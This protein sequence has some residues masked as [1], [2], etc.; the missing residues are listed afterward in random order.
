[1]NILI[2]CS[3][4]S[5]GGGGQVADSICSY[6]N[7]FPQHRFVIVYSRALKVMG[8]KVKEY[9]NVESIEYNYPLKDY[10]SLITGRNTYLD[11]LVDN[12]HID[13]VLTV[14]GPMKWKPYCPHVCGFA[15][16]H[17][18]LPESPYFRSLPLKQRLKTNLSMA[19]DTFIFRHGS[20][21]LY[22]EN[23]YITERV[24]R[25]INGSQVRTISNNYNQVFDH[26]DK[27]V[28]RRLEDF[29]GISLLT[30]ASP[31]PHK[32]IPI[33]IQIARILKDK[34]PGFKFRFVL[35]INKEDFPS[36][37]DS[38]EDCF[39]FLGKVSIEE[40]PSLYEQCD[41][42]FLP[43]LLECFSAMYAES[44][45]MRRPIITTDLPFARGLCKDAA[46]YYEPLSAEDAAEKIFSLSKNEVVQKDLVNKGVVQLKNFDT[47][48]QRAEKVFKYC[49]DVIFLKK[50]GK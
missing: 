4:L 42:A 43:S 22:T 24:Q 30:L 32:N 7:I 37:E 47:S 19:I 5:G 29:D 17:L 13:C 15:L 33:T 16:P 8:E 49:E 50:N 34:Y 11:N 6:T 14:F 27:W 9:D 10:K 1:M 12:K 36:F 26:K 41:V 20:K 18:V 21:F 28:I 25:L 2:N 48:E 45:R 46:L 39:V 40:C 31:Y 23:P 3:N 38:L 44:M 35:S